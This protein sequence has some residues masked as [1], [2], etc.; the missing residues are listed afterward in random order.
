MVRMI[1]AIIS[2]DKDAFWYTHQELDIKHPRIAL[3]I[4]KNRAHG[5]ALLEGIADYALE[6]TDWRLE[7]VDPEILQDVS[8]VRKFGGLI[9]RVMDDAT[10]DVLRKSRRPVVDTYGRRDDNPLPS[11][12]LDDAAIAEVAFTCLAEHHY[13][14]FAYCGF[15]G[16]RFSDARG[17]AFKAFAEKHGASISL[18]GGTGSVTDTFFRDEKTDVPDA[19]ALSAWLKTLSKPLALFCCNDLRAVQVM[20]IC[21]DLGLNVPKDIAVLGVDNDVLLCTFTKPSLSSVMT[22]PFALGRRAAEMLDEQMRLKGE[23]NGKRVPAK[24]GAPCLWAPK[25]VVERMSTDAYPFKTPW[26]GDAVRYIRRNFAKGVTA[27]DVDA[28]IGYSHPKVNQVFNEELGHTVK[29]EI[30]LQRTRAAC[31]LLRETDWTVSEIALRCGYQR[32]QYFV[33]SFSEEFKMTPDAWR[34]RLFQKA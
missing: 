30:L 3:Q 23:R 33:S 25:K 20:K 6:R 34:R 24:C 11:I 2:R 19:A 1:F 17:K 29:K 32:V 14:S 27:K 9:V 18:Y 13:R 21:S 31:S 7:L 15:P 8:S 12:R 28:F 4:E 16:V 26:L 10:A 22:D 5:R